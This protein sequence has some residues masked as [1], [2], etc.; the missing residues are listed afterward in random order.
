MKA[1]KSL[2]D[3]ALMRHLTASM[4]AAQAAKEVVAARKSFMGKAVGLSL[5]GL[6]AA[7]AGV[8]T[9]LCTRASL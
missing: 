4:G 8:G 2:V 1:M 6:G 9:S 3:E 7:A 5:M